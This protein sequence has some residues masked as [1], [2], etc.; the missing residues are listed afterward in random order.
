[1]AAR[2]EHQALAN[3]VV[4]G[5]KIGIDLGGNHEVATVTAV[6]K[7]ATQ[8]TLSVAAAKGAASL[9][10]ASVGNLAVGD[11]LTVDTGGRKELVT[12]KAVATAAGGGA[13]PAGGRG[14]GRG[15]RGGGGVQGTVELAAPLKLDHATGIDVSSP[16]TG[17][18]FTPATKFAH[19]SG[20]AVQALGT[21]L[22]L[23]R[24]LVNAHPHGAPVLNPPAA[25][26]YPGTPT[27]QQWFGS[28]LATGMGSLALM[29]A[30]G[31]VV[32][33]AIVYGEQQSS[34]SARG[35][36]TSP[37]LATL[38]GDQGKGGNIVVVAGGARGGGGR[39]GR[40]APAAAPGAAPAPS[41]S[42]ARLSDG[43]DTDNRTV[44]FQNQTATPGAPNQRA[45]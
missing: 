40:G 39:G 35:T 37:E 6:G 20:D 14:G 27:P 18:T 28:V 25:G 4:V 15:G 34:S 43:A 11:T 26:A 36:I 44:G 3:P 1:V 17:V 41:R 42:L 22:T 13:A 16:G 33:D 31:A 9:T 5:E 12:V 32:V 38:E 7:A 2:L 10:L 24:P 21:G 29:D 30:S 19:T 8:T 45:Q 23:D